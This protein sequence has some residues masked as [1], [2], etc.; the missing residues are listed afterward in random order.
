MKN[1]KQNNKLNKRVEIN[2]KKQRVYKN[3]KIHN[4]M[5]K[6][7]RKNIE[8]IKPD[9]LRL[10]DIKAI[11]PKPFFP[12]KRVNYIFIGILV[13]VVL[14]NFT[15]FPLSQFMSMAS[16]DEELK[17]EIGWPLPMFV[18]NFFNPEEF[19]LK[20]GGLILDLF[21]YILIAYFVDIFIS[22]ILNT[23]VMDRVLNRKE[24]LEARPKVLK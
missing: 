1:L 16:M 5:Q 11:I 18:L 7:V 12:T 19:P 8:Y 23:E 17:F 4:K 14:I 21:L 2:F 10:E 13:L 6:K 3:R 24:R 9:K 20:F 22:Y 15:K